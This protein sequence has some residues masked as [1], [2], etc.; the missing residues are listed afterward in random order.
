MTAPRPASARRQRRARAERAFSA[1]LRALGAKAE[2]ELRHG[3]GRAANL[4]T[5]HL[6]AGEGADLGKAMGRGM[7]YSAPTP[8]CIANMG[9]H[10]VCPHHLTVAFGKAHVAYLPAGRIAGLGSLSEVARL[11]TARFILQEQATEDLA[12]AVVQHLQARTAVALIEATHPCHNVPHGRSHEA[13]AITWAHAGDPAAAPELR[14]SVL[15]AL[16][17]SEI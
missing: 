8:V 3:P 10:L 15:A 16:R 14:A 5:E 13:R 6:L 12:Q 4:W 17:R 1:L 2:G 11:C 9:V 7:A